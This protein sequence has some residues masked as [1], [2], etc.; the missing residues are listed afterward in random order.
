[1]LGFFCSYVVNQILKAFG[2]DSEGTRKA[3]EGGGLKIV[4]TLDQNANDA[5][6]RRRT[7]CLPI[8]RPASEVMI[9][10]IKPGTGRTFGHQPHL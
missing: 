6:M 9:A 1:M 10:A 5:A 7:T 3:A 2:K 4:T 8:V